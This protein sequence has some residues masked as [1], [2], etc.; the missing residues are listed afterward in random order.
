M[1]LGNE[2]ILINQ[3]NVVKFNLVSQQIDHSKIPMY[4]D[5]F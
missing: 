4:P 2:Q 1:F 5:I 3:I